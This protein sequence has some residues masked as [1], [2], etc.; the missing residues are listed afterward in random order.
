VVDW[1]R[2][3]AGRVD[4]ITVVANGLG[5]VPHDLAAEVISLGKERG[6]GRAPRAARFERTIA[7]LTRGGGADAFLAHMC[8]VYVNLAAPWLR[9]RNVR[10]LLWFAHPQ[11]TPT[12]RIADRIADAIMTSLPGSYPL[13]GPKVHTIGQ[14]VDVRSFAF[15]PRERSTP[16]R[17]VAIGRTSPSKGF[18]TIVGAVGR[19]R[20]GG[21]DA[22]LRIVGPSTTPEEVRHRAELSD[23]VRER[24]G[25]AGSL[26]E[27][28]PHVDVP[29]VIREADVLVSDMVAGSGDKVVFEAAAIGRPVVVSN[30]SFSKLLADLPLDLR[31]R[32]GEDAALAHAIGALVA[33]DVRV[34]SC[35]EERSEI[36]EERRRR[37]DPANRPENAEVDNT[38]DQM[39]EIARD[40]NQPD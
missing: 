29:S 28:V 11:V 15:S 26:D 17:I 30:P 1:V 13:H 8:P 6:A 16:L 34:L 18:A 14:A 7:R 12:L 19:V 25:D 2:A 40:E 31:F 32:R 20:D 9:A 5:R 35:Q 36:E 4:S 24:L 37:L 38:G 23:L 21:V 33:A 3:L 39:P 22:R 10:S 27:G